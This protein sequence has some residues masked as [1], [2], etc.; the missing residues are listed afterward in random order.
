MR[1]K[2]VRNFLHMTTFKCLAFKLHCT[3][4]LCLPPPQPGEN[5]S[6]PPPTHTYFFFWGGGGGGGGQGGGELD[7][8]SCLELPPVV[9]R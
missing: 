6:P 1:I 4:K 7:F 2:R 8:P 5:I 9:E 3:P